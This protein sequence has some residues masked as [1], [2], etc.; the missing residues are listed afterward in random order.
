MILRCCRRPQRRFIS[1]Q[2]TTVTEPIREDETNE[3]SVAAVEGN[4]A[5]ENV[6]RQHQDKLRETEE[7][8]NKEAGEVNPRGNEGELEEVAYES[9][10]VGFCRICYD[11]SSN[12]ELISPCNC[13][14]T[15]GLVHR[16]C[17][18]HWLM[19]SRTSSCELCGYVFDTETSYRY[20]R[21]RS[22][23][24]CLRDPAA[25]F[26]RT[27]L[28]WDFSTFIFLT[29]LVSFASYLCLMG[30]YTYAKQSKGPGSSAFT[31]AVGL[32]LIV[33]VLVLSYIVSLTITIR[34]NIR[35]LTTWRRTN[36]LVRI[37]SQSNR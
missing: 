5:H 14:G 2:Q 29:F 32:I 30:A 10:S 35:N 4:T 22:L 21:M 15:M 31:T 37:V 11:E 25:G 12:D 34:N 20:N 23:W 19:E 13:H 9:E 27:Q 17:L 16:S 28:I 24:E 1:I 7:G 6:R 33:G 36:I 3:I 18:E 26:E 8:R